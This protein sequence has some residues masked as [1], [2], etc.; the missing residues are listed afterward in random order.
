MINKTALVI[1]AALVASPLTAVLA[2]SAADARPDDDHV[3]CNQKFM[4]Y[5]NGKCLDARNT[6]S[7]FWVFTTRNAGDFM[8][9]KSNPCEGLDPRLCALDVD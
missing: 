9:K 3:N 6:P 2:P 1:V 8:M 7:D 5:D 4:Y